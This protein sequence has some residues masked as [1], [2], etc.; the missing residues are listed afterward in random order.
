M[1]LR[2][3]SE[4][5]KEWE[6]MR[7]AAPDLLAGLDH[8]IIPADIADRGTFYRLQIGPFASRGAANSRCNALKSA[9]FS[10]Y[11]LAPEN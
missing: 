11:Y 4:A 8:Q 10:C 1:A 2:S 6:A 7:A 5:Q 3:E 9:G